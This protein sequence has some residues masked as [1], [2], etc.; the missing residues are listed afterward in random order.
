M[1]INGEPA[2]EQKLYSG[3][4][5]EV[6]KGG[7]LLRFRLYPPG[8][9]AYKSMMEA[10]S[11]CFDC[12]RNSAEDPLGR[13]RILLQG[14]PREVARET[15]PWARAGVTLLILTLEASVA[16]LLL[17]SR[18][19]KRQIAQQS[20]QL[21]AISSELLELTERNAMGSEDLD[22]VRAELG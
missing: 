20:Q 15:S 5:L 16:F 22:R 13:A 11:D 8:S 3:D 21:Q 7:P 12:A 1:W 6:G 17:R 10:F 14:I 19:L 4:V 2:A 18:Q 9:P